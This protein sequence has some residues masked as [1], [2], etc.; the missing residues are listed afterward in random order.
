MSNSKLIKSLELSRSLMRSQIEVLRE[1]AEDLCTNY[2]IEWKERNH[3]EI[4]LPRP[5]NTLKREASWGSYAPKIELI[6]NAKKV[7]ITWHKFSPFKTRSPSH[8]SKRISAMKS[9]K[10]SKSCFVN[11]AFWQ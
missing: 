11:H 3:L 7:T 5:N 9:G 4:N 1:A 8:M 10:Y 6:G 2:W